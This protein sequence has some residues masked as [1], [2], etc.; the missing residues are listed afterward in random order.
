MNKAAF[1]ARVM[2]ILRENAASKW[3]RHR[4]DGHLDPRSLHEYV[5]T[6]DIW[7]LKEVAG[8]RKYS[9][10]F[11]LDMSGSMGGPKADAAVSMA[12][13]F[14]DSMHVLGIPFAIWAFGSYP[15]RVHG[16]SDYYSRP[17]LE[18]RLKA[19]YC[20][21]PFAIDAKQS[22][23]GI[24]DVSRWD[25][26]CSKL[27]EAGKIRQTSERLENVS[28][29]LGGT[30]PALVQ[31]LAISEAAQLDAEPLIIL[32]SDGEIGLECSYNYQRS[33]KPSRASLLPVANLYAQHGKPFVESLLKAGFSRPADESGM[34]AFM[35]GVKGVFTEDASTLDIE[36]LLK[37]GPTGKVFARIGE[38]NANRWDTGLDLN[39][40]FNHYVVKNVLGGQF[41]FMGVMNESFHN[42]SRAGLVPSDDVFSVHN[43]AQGYDAI[44]AKLSSHFK[45]D[46]GKKLR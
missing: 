2:E 29:L 21:Y 12:A 43:L 17:R 28:G 7:R 41:L 8:S 14:A 5:T 24:N 9:A 31:A 23:V 20:G 11:I 36:G 16:F 19:T 3:R 34:Y 10:T 38:G 35:P 37:Y 39:A 18:A 40:A 45:F 13:K 15:V 30:A 33:T 32:M 44:V 27:A 1:E 6:P 42:Y 22:L 25:D 4:E 26:Q 46:Y